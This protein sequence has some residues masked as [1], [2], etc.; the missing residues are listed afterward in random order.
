MQAIIDQEETRLRFLA[1]QVAR[2]QLIAYALRTVSGLDAYV[3]LTADATP[4]P[5]LGLLRGAD[6]PVSVD[7]DATASHIEGIVE[8]LQHLHKQCALYVHFYQ[9]VAS[10]NFEQMGAAHRQLIAIGDADIAAAAEGDMDAEEVAATIQNI[11]RQEENRLAFVDKVMWI[12]PLDAEDMANRA[13]AALTTLGYPSRIYDMECFLQ[14][15]R[16]VPELLG[17]AEAGEQCAPFETRVAPPLCDS[18][19]QARDVAFAAANARA[20]VAVLACEMKHGEPGHSRLFHCVAVVKN[21]QN[22]DVVVSRCGGLEQCSPLVLWLQQNNFPA[23]LA[24]KVIATTPR[25]WTR[26]ADAVQHHVFGK[27]TP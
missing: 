17:R 7:A 6:I 21:K 27:N 5:V 8:H 1:Q 3:Q 4:V 16:V 26:F 9:S 2:W 15:Y 12:P 24:H 23:V 25:D 18:M 22:V 11:K 10:N 19:T 20:Y 13:A 14:T